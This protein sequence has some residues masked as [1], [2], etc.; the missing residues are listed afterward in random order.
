MDIAPVLRYRWK[1]ASLGDGI[2][3]FL[4][5]GWPTLFGFLEFRRNTEL[6]AGI[7]SKAGGEYPERA[8]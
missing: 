5:F 7:E 4:A 1:V 3:G 8:L 6:S 2:L